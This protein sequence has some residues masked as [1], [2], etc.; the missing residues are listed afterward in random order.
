MRGIGLALI[1]AGFVF[2]SSE[3]DAGVI[4]RA[5][6]KADRPGATVALCSC[7]QSVADQKLTRRDKRRVA[8]WFADPHQ[9][10]VTRQSNHWAD[11]QL[12]LRYRDFGEHASKVC[13]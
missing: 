1:A 13:R 12:W 6:Q 8:K 10:Q 11:E 2:S 4:K 3:A 7:I 5:C 9:A